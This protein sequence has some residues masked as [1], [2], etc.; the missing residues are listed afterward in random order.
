MLSK[1]LHPRLVDLSM[2]DKKV[3]L[4]LVDLF[5]L[6]KTSMAVLVLEHTAVNL[7]VLVLVCLVAEGVTPTAFVCF[8]LIVITSKSYIARC[9][10]LVSG[11]CV[12]R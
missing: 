3:H 2:F 8:N 4:R 1:E 5:M 11:R 9:F 10:L 6:V 7:L 12:G